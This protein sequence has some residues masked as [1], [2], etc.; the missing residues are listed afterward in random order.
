MSLRR[1]TIAAILLAALPALWVVAQDTLPPGRQAQAPRANDPQFSQIISYAIGRSVAQ[2]SNLAGVEINLESFQKAVADEARGAPSPYTD[3]QLGQAMDQFSRLIQAAIARQNKE[4]GEAFLAKNAQQEGVVTTQSGLQY[5]V[6]REGN[7]ASP[8]PTDQVTCHYRGTFINGEV[9][10]S[11]Y[12]SGRPATFP[13]GGVIKGWTEALQLMKVGA[14]Y[15]LF[16]PSELAYGAGGRP[17]IGPN[18]TLIFEVELLQVTP[19]AAQVP[20]R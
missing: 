12:E 8:K 7:G 1:W 16:V 13:V 4:Q 17:G 14:K 19:G 3:E 2:E 6:L 18:S 10:D 20:Q 9:F 15:Q 11:S 5:K